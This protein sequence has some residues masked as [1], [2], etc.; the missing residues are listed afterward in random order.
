MILKDDLYLI[1]LLFII[2][3][4]VQFWLLCIVMVQG[5]AREHWMFLAEYAGFIRKMKGL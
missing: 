1:I 4:M 3:L 2:T 5:I